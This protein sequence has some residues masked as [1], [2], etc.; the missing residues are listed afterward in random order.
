M[1]Q[2]WLAN[3]TIW[4]QQQR[5]RS[6]K[7]KAEHGVSQ[8]FLLRPKVSFTTFELK[9]KR[10]RTNATGASWRKLSRYRQGEM[11]RPSGLLRLWAVLLKTGRFLMSS[12]HKKT[13]K[14]TTTN[15]HRSV[16]AK[17]LNFPELGFQPINLVWNGLQLPR[18]KSNS[19]KNKIPTNICILVIDSVMLWR[20]FNCLS[21]YRCRC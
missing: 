2:N 8:L 3:E 20:D 21:V 18:V 15:G 14:K 11:E 16:M 19:S 1:S 5:T 4:R 6:C 12:S 17:V 7:R 9:Q 13:H 10:R